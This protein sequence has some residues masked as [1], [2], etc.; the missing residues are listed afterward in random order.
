MW[1]PVAVP[2]GIVTETVEVPP[3]GT[4]VG[5]M[6]PVRSVPVVG[7]SRRKP[8]VWPPTKLVICPVAV[9]GSALIVVG[10]SV[11]EGAATVAAVL[12]PLSAPRQLL[13]SGVTV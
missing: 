9:V 8:T 10:V 1:A 12:C 7:L 13:L 6:L 11:R 4:G 3:A 5:A 2:A